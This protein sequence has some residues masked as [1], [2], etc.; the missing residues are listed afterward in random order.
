MAFRP[1]CDA[2]TVDP[3][4]SNR[5]ERGHQGNLGAVLIEVIRSKLRKIK[6]VECRWSGLCH[7][8][9]GGADFTRLL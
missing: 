7:S 9:G 4:Q 5:R 6:Q 3:G 8:L 1:G 2:T